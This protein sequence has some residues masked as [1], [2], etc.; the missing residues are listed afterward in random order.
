LDLREQVVG[1]EERSSEVKQLLLGSDAH[2]MQL[3]KRKG[4]VELY[5]AKIALSSG[6]CKALHESEAASS[7]VLLFFGVF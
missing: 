6:T 7:S 5:L 3:G 4:D 2:T 1:R